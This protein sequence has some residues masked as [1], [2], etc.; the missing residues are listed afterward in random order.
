VTKFRLAWAR[1]RGERKAKEHGFISF[2][3]DPFRIAQTEDIHVEP[4]P[5][6]QPGV[7]GGIIFADV[8]TAIFYATNISSGGFQRFTVAHELGHYFLEGH[9][10]EIQKTGPLHVSRAGFTQGDS[11]IEIEAD[12]FAS[13][14]L[15]PTSLVRQALDRT[16]IGLAGIEKLAADS[17]CSLTASAIR[18]AE[19]SPYPMAVVVSR[20]DRICY[21]FLSDGFKQLKPRAFPRKGD[22]LPYTATREFNSEQSNVELR[23]RRA[24]ETTLAEWFDGS[25]GVR[26]DEE[27]MGLGEYGFTLSVFS[28]EELPE[29]PDEAEDEEAALIESYTPRFARGR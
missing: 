12:H 9:P 25:P 14:L 10:E 4:K 6:D 15:M 1:Q 23:R 8:G 16:C 17:E 22:P 7:S 11:S 18:S 2:P 5:S 27:V 3:I 26:L 20:G 24:S 19:C 13:G 29:E 28:S 21:G